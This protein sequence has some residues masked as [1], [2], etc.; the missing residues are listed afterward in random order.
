MAERASDGA[1]V[2]NRPIGDRAR[3]TLHRAARD[4]GYSSVLDV[5]MGDTGADHE[6]I[7]MAFGSL[8]F[9]KSGYVDN[10]LRFDQP[11]VE[12]RAQ[13]LTSGNNLGRSACSGH[14][15]KRGVQIGGTFI[16]ERCRFHAADLSASRAAR[17]ASTIRRGEIGECRSSTRSGRNASFT[18]LAMAAGG[19][20]AP[21]SPMPLTPNIV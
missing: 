11:Q 4:I 10:Q 12:H 3:N 13:R 5:A 1:A 20:M 21:P 6:L 17:M 15:G 16:G 2:A 8:Q 14:Q 18:A 19:A 7:A 9:G